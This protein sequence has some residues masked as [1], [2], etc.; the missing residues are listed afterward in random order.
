[1]EETSLEVTDRQSSAVQ[2]TPNR[3]SLDYIKSRITDVEYINPVGLPTMTIAVVYYENG[4][5]FVGQAAP[6][7][8]EL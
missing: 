3:V 6:A 1:M 5:V 7:D 8:P 4:F 2:K